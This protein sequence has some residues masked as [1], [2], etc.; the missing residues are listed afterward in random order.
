MAGKKISEIDAMKQID[1]LLQKVGDV[2]AKARIVSWAAS[3]YG[4]GVAI[5]SNTKTDGKSLNARKGKKKIVKAKNSKLRVTSSLYIV[6]ELNLRPKEKTSFSDFA[7]QKAPRSI[8][9]KMVVAV[10]YLKNE[11]SIKDVGLNHIYT[12]FKVVK[13]RNPKNYVNMLLQAGSAGWLDA[14]DQ[15]NI[16]VTP[17]GDNLI[18]HELPRKSKKV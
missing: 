18:E 2:S 17:M 4:S 11:I 5:P 9:E 3:K 13:W 14:R 1:E 7:N 16:L 10:Y 12:C 6:K 8:K 15:S